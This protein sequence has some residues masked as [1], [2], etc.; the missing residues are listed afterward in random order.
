M[1]KN[2]KDLAESLLADESRGWLSGFL[3]DE[4]EFDRH[5]LWR[6]GSWGIGSVGA[7]IIAVLANQSGSALR[8]DQVAAVDLARQ[9][10]QLQTVAKANENETRRLASAVD[11]LNGDR[12]RLYAR[13]TVLEQGLDSVTGSINRKSAEQTNSKKAALSLPQAAALPSSP[14]DKAPVSQASVAPAAVQGTMPS[15]ATVTANPAASS[16]VQ[17]DAP[18]NAES[19][20]NRAP[21]LPLVAPVAS[22]APAT[23]REAV[24]GKFSAAKS[25]L[26]K[27][28]S[29]KA[30]PVNS[31][32]AIYSSAESS[33]KTPA[34]A[35]AP[36]AITPLIPSKSEI[37]PLDLPK[38][39]P[40]RP[41]D[42]ATAAPAKAAAQENSETKIEMAAIPKGVDA[43]PAAPPLP[44]SG[45]V[46]HTEFG[47]DLGSAR[48]I[49]GLRALWRGLLKSD[50]KQVASL[51]PIIVLKERANGSG[52]QLRLVAGP[53]NDAAAAAKICAVLVENDR[54][55]ETSVF[56]G[57]RLPMTNDGKENG[58]SATVKKPR[59]SPSSSRHRRG[60][61]TA[62]V[63]E[64]A[65]SP[66]PP[67][68]STI[69]SFFSR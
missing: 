11:T 18:K 2:R 20:A 4:D 48:S 16:A 44:G 52:M 60:R 38:I 3:A 50:A 69:G 41:N 51:Q 57:Q 28:T 62:Q 15:S 65:P 32:P 1:A 30:S 10:Q 54:N 22:T 29:A 64:P 58:R 45:P 37:A 7:V 61:T 17:P 12:D 67:K 8:R 47:V 24:T 27:L 33:S 9:S 19:S 63:E 5:T 23:P 25:A 35:A 6:L 40:D 42:V 46:A 55:C 31:T 59:P 36:M 43:E 26:A 66:P 49:N 68:P 56:D 53:L 39:K 14:L 34:S 21:P 13:V